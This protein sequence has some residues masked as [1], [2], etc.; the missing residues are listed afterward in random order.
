[1][2]TRKSSINRAAGGDELLCVPAVFNKDG[3]RADRREHAF[4]EARGD[5]AFV[6]AEAVADDKV[7]RFT[8]QIDEAG[9]GDELDLDVGVSCAEGRQVGHE[10]LSREGRQSRDA[11]DVRACW[12]AMI[13]RE[14]VAHHREGGAERFGEGVAFLRQ[15]QAGGRAHEDLRADEI[16]ERDDVLGDGAL[17]H[18][19]FFGG[20]RKAEMAGGGFEG[21]QGI[22]RWK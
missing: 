11:A 1:M 14:G 6:F 16:L 9:G 8:R 17:R 2:A 20:A 12:A 22:E 10:E 21:P 13:L 5:E 7:R 3:R 18:A 19:E 15:R 4:D